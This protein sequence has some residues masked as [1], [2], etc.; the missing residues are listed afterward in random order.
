MSIQKSYL[1]NGNGEFFLLGEGLTPQEEIE[2]AEEVAEE[3]E[4]YIGDIVYDRDILSHEQV[5]TMLSSLHELLKS[6]PL[7]VGIND[8]NGVGIK[9]GDKMRLPKDKDS[10]VLTV[11]YV[12]PSFWLCDSDGDMVFNNWAYFRERVIVEVKKHGNR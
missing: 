9:E 1:L 3:N 7:Y 12:A 5:T 8:A 6:E 2:R 11:R 4:F 10:E